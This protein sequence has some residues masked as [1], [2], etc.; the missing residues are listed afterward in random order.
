VR[1][2]GWLV[3]D[4]NAGSTTA[5]TRARIGVRK[6]EWCAGVSG[7]LVRLATSIAATQDVA[8]QIDPFDMGTG[9]RVGRTVSHSEKRPKTANCF[10]DVLL[11]LRYDGIAGSKVLLRFLTIQRRF[12]CGE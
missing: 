10:I 9:R 3:R 7:M 6:L 11:R 1:Q 8:K 4:W 5:M 2:A 12:K